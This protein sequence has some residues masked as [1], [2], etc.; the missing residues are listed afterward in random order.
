MRPFLLL[1]LA[2]LPGCPSCV[3]LPT[4]APN[5]PPDAQDASWLDVAPPLADS[6]PPAP[7]PP[8]P[9]DLAGQAC[10]RL[11]ALGC[12]LGSSTRC[13]DVMSLDPR[14][15]SPACVVDAGSIADLPACGVNC[16]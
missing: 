15:V 10:A 14:F 8:T 4:P 13:H 11:V 16:N 12:P 6:A 5:P 1:V 2:L 9:T 7:P 3:P